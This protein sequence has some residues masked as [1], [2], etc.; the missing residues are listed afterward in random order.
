MLDHV[1]CARNISVMDRN[2]STLAPFS[3]LWNWFHAEI[4]LSRGFL[5]I[6]NAK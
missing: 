1:I 3:I 4:N 6:A 2:S 5:T